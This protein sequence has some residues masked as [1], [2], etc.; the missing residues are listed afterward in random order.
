MLPP[1]LEPMRGGLG[2]RGAVIGQAGGIWQVLAIS[3][4]GESRVGVGI[5]SRDGGVRPS[6]QVDFRRMN[7]ETCDWPFGGGPARPG[8]IKV[9][10]L[11][12]VL[13]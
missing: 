12:A 11:G 6:S 3:T 13:T 8:P 1:P 2:P 10:M 9:S 4:N 7:G 5:Q